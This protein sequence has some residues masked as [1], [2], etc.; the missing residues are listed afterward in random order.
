MKKIL[1]LALLVFSLH[2]DEPVEYT[3]MDYS[4]ITLGD[5]V[6]LYAGSLNMQC[7]ETAQAYALGIV[8]HDE[9]QSIF[10][11]ALGYM[12][13]GDRVF[14]YFYESPSLLHAHQSD[15]GV[16]FYLNYRF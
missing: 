3:L 2:A 10:D 12:Q 1:V 11:F 4:N 9:E 6:S 8:F 7:F 13:P 15:D 16:L 14:E 5:Y